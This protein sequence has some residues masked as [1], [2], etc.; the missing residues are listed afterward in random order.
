MIHYAQQDETKKRNGHTHPKRSF[1]ADVREE[2]DMKILIIDDS[3]DN[4]ASARQTLGA[5]DVTI[6][7]TYD[8]AYRLLQR[9]SAPFDV[10]LTDLLMP[11]G[12]RIQCEKSGRAG[13]E[14]VG[15]EMPVGFGL[16]LDAVL[17][18]AK[19][20]AVVS[21]GDHHSHPA[22]AM[23]DR[24]GSYSGWNTECGPPPVRFEIN[25]AKVGFFRV[26]WVGDGQCK[27]ANGKYAKNWGRVLEH[28]LDTPVTPD[29]EF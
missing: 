21:D 3:T 29:V 6:V 2:I 12:A 1:K 17:H 5:H 14:F 22:V 20:V 4:Q 11:A 9:G 25:G 16:A 23:L 15:Q 7:G 28:L 13:N 18:G 26:S 24:L 8:E 27:L 19:Y 10:V